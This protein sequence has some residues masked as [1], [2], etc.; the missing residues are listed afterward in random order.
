MSSIV[1][2]QPAAAEGYALD[3]GPASAQARP[4]AAEGARPFRLAALVVAAVALNGLVFAG[5]HAVVSLAL[6]RALFDMPPLPG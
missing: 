2:P 1:V 4:E 6:G 3:A 5:L